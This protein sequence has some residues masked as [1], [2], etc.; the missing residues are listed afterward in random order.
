M[1]GEIH[2]NILVYKSLTS[3]LPPQLCNVFNY[4]ATAHSYSTR[5]GSQGTLVPQLLKTDSGKR[6]IS[7]RG[8][9]SFNQLPVTLKNSL[10][11]TVAL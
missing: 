9:N 11:C 7:T 5:S 3:T 4:A 10:P 8:V 2:L 1:P 6:K